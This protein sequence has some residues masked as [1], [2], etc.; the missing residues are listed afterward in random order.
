MSQNMDFIIVSIHSRLF[1]PGESNV[2]T[3]AILRA[4]VSIHSRLFKPGEYL[5]CWLGYDPSGVSIH[6]RLFKPG[7]LADDASRLLPLL[8]FQSTPDYLNRENVTPMQ[9]VRAYLFVSIHS[10]LF[11]PGE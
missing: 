3:V 4:T 11:K 2:G 1:K 9:V 10:R 7:E 8:E 5:P 6:S